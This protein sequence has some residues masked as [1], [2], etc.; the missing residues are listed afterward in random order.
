[1]FVA[2]LTVMVIV[3]ALAVVFG[4]ALLFSS[5]KGGARSAFPDGLKRQTQLEG[6][7]RVSPEGNNKQQAATSNQK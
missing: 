2:V 4:A 6:F 5:P 7:R 3:V 1:V